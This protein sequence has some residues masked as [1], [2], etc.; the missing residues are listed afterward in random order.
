[1]QI[2]ILLAH[3]TSY[4][5]P[6]IPPNMDQ[7]LHSWPISTSHNFRQ[8]WYH[9]VSEL[10]FC[11]DRHSITRLDGIEVLCIHLRS[12]VFI[13]RLFHSLG[14]IASY[15][16]NSQCFS[17]NIKSAFVT[18]YYFACKLHTVVNYFKAHNLKINFEELVRA[19]KQ[20][21]HEPPG[22]GTF[23]QNWTLTDQGPGL[24][25]PA[26]LDSRWKDWNLASQRRI[27][28]ANKN[29]LRTDW[30][31]TWCSSFSNGQNFFY[32]RK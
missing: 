26:G 14:T 22:R 30:I 19:A 27:L 12:T 10:S 20:H 23:V 31:S 3:S 29:W 17:S 13:W 7:Y 18:N 16:L 4:I 15:R 11:F 2:I 32:R 8:I 5:V 28:E 24:N 1:M 25:I 21:H 9:H 6:Y